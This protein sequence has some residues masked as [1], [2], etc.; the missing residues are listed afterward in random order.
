MWGYPSGAID[1]K[2]QRMPSHLYGRY[3][4]ILVI[5]LIN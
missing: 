1:A 3:A 4:G 2:S 5:L